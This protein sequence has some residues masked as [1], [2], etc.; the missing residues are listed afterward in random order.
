MNRTETG[1]ARETWVL[2]KGDALAEEQGGR[3][4]S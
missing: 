1:H 4:R 2:Q 3:V